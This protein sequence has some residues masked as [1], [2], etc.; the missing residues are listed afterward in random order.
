MT[1]AFGGAIFQEILNRR[2]PTYLCLMVFFY[3]LLFL[4][5]FSTDF[6]YDVIIRQLRP[7]LTIRFVFLQ[8]FD[9][10]KLHWKLALRRGN[11]HTG[12]V[13][14]SKYSGN[15]IKHMVSTFNLGDVMY[16]TVPML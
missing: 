14:W 5:D 11:W 3:G 6:V 1:E 7:D 16:K 12:E 2:P 8:S 4:C 10:S 9:S 15:I 13:H